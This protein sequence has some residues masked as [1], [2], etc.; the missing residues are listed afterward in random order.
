VL[1]G[2]SALLLV[3]GACANKD[4]SDH[5][6]AA[7]TVT[8]VGTS[9]AGEEDIQ[10]TRPD[11]DSGAA[12]GSTLNCG[13]EQQG[14]GSGYDPAARECLWQAYTAGEGAVFTTTRPTIEGDPI[15][16]HID[17]IATD[18]IDVTADNTADRFA[19]LEARGVTTVTCTS[20]AITDDGS[21]DF[22]FEVRGCDGEAGSTLVI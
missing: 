5:P 10:T 17:V 22:A 18:R 12:G 16:W 14:H 20:M 3:A 21:N 1:L 6:S 15:V 11:T 8:A 2:L 7:P 9:T 19:A 4:G 13:E